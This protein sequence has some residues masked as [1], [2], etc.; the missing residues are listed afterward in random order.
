M[1]DLT[2]YGFNHTAFVVSDLDRTIGFF[3]ELLGFE[4]AS[5]APRDAKAIEGMTGLEGVDIEIAYLRGFGQW[6]ELIRYKAPFGRGETPPKIYQDGAGHV[7]LDVA[8]IEAAVLA[9]ADYGLT[10][11]GD[12]VTIDQGPNQ[13][14]K[15]VYLQ[16]PDGLSVEFIEVPL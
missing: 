1:S 15:V 7:A 5:R 8:D 14:R 3:K 13:G 6:I 11:I 12:I 2:I 10:S 16:S 9:S 4:L